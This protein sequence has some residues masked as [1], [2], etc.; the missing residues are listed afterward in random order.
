[1]NWPLPVT[2]LRSSLRGTDVPTTR[3][4][5]RVSVVAIYASAPTAAVRTAATMFW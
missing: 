5:V 1:M 2:S 4:V 3:P